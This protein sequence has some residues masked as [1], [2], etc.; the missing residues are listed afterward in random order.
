MRAESDWATPVGIRRIQDKT[1][2]MLQEPLTGLTIQWYVSKRTSDE[3]VHLPHLYIAVEQALFYRMA[4]YLASVRNLDAPIHF[5]S[6][7]AAARSVFELGLD[8]ALLEPT[9]QTKPSTGLPPLLGLNAT[10]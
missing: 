1:R 3:Y 2:E 5:Q 6:I 7:A 10:E 8:I 4:A 9:R